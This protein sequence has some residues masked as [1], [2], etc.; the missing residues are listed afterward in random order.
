VRSDA[1]AASGSGC[2]TAAVSSMSG[3]RTLLAVLPQY[4]QMLS[5]QYWSR[6][7]LEDHTHRLLAET[8]RAAAAIPFYK[9]R[10]GG[11]VEPPA[12]PELPT[13]KRADILKLN[14]S[15]RECLRPGLTYFADTSSGSTGMPVEFLFDLGHQAGR[16]AARI[17][18]LRAN[19][20]NPARRNVWIISLT[21]GPDEV[22]EG[23]LLKSRAVLRSYFPPIIFDPFDDQVDHLIELD[24]LFLYTFPSNLEGLLK[25]FER[26]GVRL[27]S[28][29]RIFSGAEVLEDSIRDR[30][31]KLLGVEI[32]DNYGS[33]EGFIAWQCP[34]GTYHVNAEH[35]LMEIVDDDNRPAAP[36]QMGRVL[37]TTL[38]NRL[39]P[40]VRYEIGDYA[41][42][43]D[44]LC[45]CGR[46]LPVIEK[47]I[48]RGIN[49]FRAPDGRLVASWPLV[50]P[51]RDVP[52]IRQFQVVQETPD[53]CTVRFVA[54][55]PLGREIEAQ[56]TASFGEILKFPVSVAFDQ[57]GEIP[58]SS[59]GKFM[60]LL[61]KLAAGHDGNI[62]AGAGADAALP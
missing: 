62:R 34:R 16:Y 5:L 44:R 4:R 10:L 26:R 52:Q 60:T 8:L 7:R 9:E 17:R 50:G 53:R 1:F 61:S 47:V 24:P 21:S 59:G 23:A 38:Q 12:L 56:I 22:P 28:L 57:V 11:S 45:A 18:Y 29:R 41:I 25:S 2:D 15:V 3:I 58:R 37:I 19:G 30:A 36:G 42:S 46:T 39:M 32:S 20:W 55:Q 40:L 31:R 48:G 33:T 43:S 54:N 6:E 13:L 14:R 51:L 35:V 49:L 27:R